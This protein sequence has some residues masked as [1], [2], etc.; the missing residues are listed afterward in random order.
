M[1]EFAR[2]QRHVRNVGICIRLAG[3]MENCTCVEE[4]YNATT[5]CMGKGFFKEVTILQVLKELPA[6]YGAR[7]L[8]TVLTQFATC[9]Y[10]FL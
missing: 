1:Q 7:M 5:D 4:G 6:L 10:L 9:R 8:F 3:W 2:T